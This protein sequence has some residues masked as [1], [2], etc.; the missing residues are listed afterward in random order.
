V[1]VAWDGERAQRD[2]RPAGRPLSPERVGSAKLVLVLHL[3]RF[4]PDPARSPEFLARLWQGRVP[5][6][7]ALR[8]WLYPEDEPGVVLLLWEGDD[9]AG[10]YVER[11]FA[12]FGRTSTS[13][14]RDATPAMAACMARDLEGFGAFLAGGSNPDEVARQV[15]LR[16]RGL[17]AASPEEAGE[18][19][20][21]WAAE[22]ARGVDGSPS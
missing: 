5:A 3:T 20:R 10:A 21:A 11:T 13:R 8:S 18:A 4:E 16:R 12:A 2:C 15:E 17:N 7:F 22:Q 1:T 14:L 19:G 6:A 9:S